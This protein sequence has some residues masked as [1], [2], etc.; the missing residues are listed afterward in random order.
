MIGS[1]AAVLENNP[2]QTGAAP[3][4]EGDGRLLRVVFCVFLYAVPAVTALHPVSELDTWWHLRTGRWIVENGTVP[5]VDSFSRFGQGKPWLAYSWLFEWMLYGLYQEWGLTGIVVYRVLLALA[6]AAALHVL[7]ARRLAN[8]ALTAGLVAAAAVAMTPLLVGERP[9]LFTLLFSILTL[10]AIQSLREGTRRRLVWLLPVCY[11]LWANLHIQFVYGLFLLG[12]ACAAPLLD[13]ML[14][15]ERRGENAA[16][17]G[18]RGWRQLVMLTGACALATLVNPYGVHVYNVVRDYGGQK[19]I[20]QLFGELKAPEFRQVSDWV[21]LGLAGMAVFT[22]GRRSRI[23]SFDVLLLAA[24]AYF[25]FH[26][27]RDL[28]LLVVASVAVIVQGK[29]PGR[30]EALTWPERLLAAVGVL[31]VV[32]GA[33][34]LRGLSEETLEK[35]VAMEF[36]V[37]AAAFVEQ[38]GY[39]APVYNHID[40]GG[41]LI[42]RL[43]HLPAAID[44]RANLHGD[45]RIKRFADTSQGMPGW[46]RD[47][48]LAAARLVILQA[49]APLT[50]LLRLDR[51]FVL[52]YEDAVAV[53][54]VARAKPQAGRVGDLPTLRP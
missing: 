18:S 9:G 2:T 49:P 34:W 22:L 4:P 51:R 38:H 5:D 26:A 1:P 3:R 41:Y 19:E 21:L 48:D 31:L 16:A 6:I 17:W 28:W 42:W 20:Y 36:P 35:Q 53:V 52:A 12:L 15:L 37:A 8:P 44:G 32:A 46:D 13:R 43:P 27:R 40:W 54:F 33:V 30:A 23:S 7:M 24:A 14:G 11:A 45:A 39:P 29:P 47:P 10:D 50:A 25:A